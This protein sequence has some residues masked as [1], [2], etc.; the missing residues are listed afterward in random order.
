MTS[1]HPL[2]S[3][4]PVIARVLKPMGDGQC[5]PETTKNLLFHWHRGLNKE[6]SGIPFCSKRSLKEGR[7][8]MRIKLFNV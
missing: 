3:P 8:V 2:Q 6:H 7:S 1:R 4:L 5:M